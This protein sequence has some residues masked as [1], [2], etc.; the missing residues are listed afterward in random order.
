MANWKYWKGFFAGIATAILVIFALIEGTAKVKDLFTNPAEPQILDVQNCL[1]FPIVN[2]E[3]IRFELLVNN[4]GTKDCSIIS[5]DLTWPDGLDAELFTSLPKT[6]PAG[7][8]EKV[9]IKGWGHKMQGFRSEGK[10][11]LQ[12]DQTTAEATVTVKF[13]TKHIIRKKITFTIER[14]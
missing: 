3:D 1:I 13:N 5:I 12:P 9:V 8:T 14:L 7:L 6:I 10:L 4:P 11:E 2:N